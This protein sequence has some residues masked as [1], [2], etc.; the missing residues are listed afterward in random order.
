VL[1]NLTQALTAEFGRGWSVDSISLMRRFYLT[2]S[3]RL[4]ISETP[5][6]ISDGEG[7]TA[8]SPSVPATPEALSS[9]PAFTLS[10]SH[11]VFLV[12]IDD[13]AERSFY[14][15]EAHRDGWALRELRR[16]FDTSLYERLALSRDKDGV[17]A[18]AVN[19]QL[20]STPADLL[21]DPYVLEF[22]GM[23]ERPRYSESDLEGRIIDKLE[24][25]LLELGK[26]FLFEGRQRRF[27]FDEEHYYVDL[28]F[29]N[30]LLRCFVL[31]DLKIGKITHQDLGQMQMYVNFYDRHV[32]LDEETPTIGIILCKKKHDAL[33]EITLPEGANVHAREYRLV[34]PSKADL[35]AKL[36]EWTREDGK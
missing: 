20:I 8:I 7:A 34:L 4:P 5:S 9:K 26:G 2:Y 15:V 36:L 31:V 3:D 13:P 18:L 1:R 10:W 14:E 12:G 33:V 28:V 27:T 24:H 29:Y 35:R 22:L 19:G 23:E 32:K 17:P 11:Y 30:R 6:R 16:Q 25:F 21:K